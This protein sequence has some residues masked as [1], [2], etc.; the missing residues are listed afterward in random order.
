MDTRIQEKLR[1]FAAT[2]D[3]DVAVAVCAA[4]LRIRGGLEVGSMVQIPTI[5]TRI[6]LTEDWTFLLEAED[7]NEKFH[8]AIHPVETTLGEDGYLYQLYK[9]KFGK[10][11]RRRYNG[12]QDTDTTL[13]AGTVLRVDRIYIKK[14]QG[15][16]DSV[17]F[18]CE[19]IPGRENAKLMS[20]K[21]AKTFGRFWSALNEANGIVGS[22]DAETLPGAEGP[23]G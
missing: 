14:N 11:K 2:E 10:Q 8:D 19:S 12:L 21:S 17:T 18:V 1:K 7:R 4:L 13:P 3:P 16:Y 23:G 15:D 20:G 22:W 9:D 6:T 5:G